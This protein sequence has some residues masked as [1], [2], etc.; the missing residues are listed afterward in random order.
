ML[1]AGITTRDSGCLGPDCSLD[2]ERRN[3]KAQLIDPWL[4][5]TTTDSLH[6]LLNPGPVDRSRNWFRSN[7]H[8]RCKS[9]EKD[10]HIRFIVGAVSLKQ[11]KRVGWA[12]IIVVLNFLW[13]REVVQSL[14]TFRRDA[15]TAVSKI[16]WEVTRTW[17]WRWRWLVT[18]GPREGMSPWVW[19]WPM[20]RAM[21]AGAKTA[22]AIFN[23]SLHQRW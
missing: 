23:R 5:S 8:I 18:M 20:M 21:P 22:L 11:S 4:G 3:T 15:V 1:L 13:A 17:W 6:T 10:V 9:F 7:W 14:D 16:F 2:G 12:A 19:T